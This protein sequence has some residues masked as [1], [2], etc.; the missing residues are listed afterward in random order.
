MTEHTPPPEEQQQNPPGQEPRQTVSSRD[1]IIF[2]VM[3]VLALGLILY[4]VAEI[5]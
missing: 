2:A 1:L 4:V 5:T 3:G